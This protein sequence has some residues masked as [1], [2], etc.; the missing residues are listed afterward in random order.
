MLDMVEKKTTVSNHLK[1]RQLK[2]VRNFWVPMSSCVFPVLISF[3]IDS[4]TH[5]ESYCLIVW[6]RVVDW[7]FDS[8]SGSH[9]QGQ[10]N[11]VCQSMML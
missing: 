5:I 10:V 6:A 8:L 7:R 2:F 1:C 4:A 3:S 11:S 9:L